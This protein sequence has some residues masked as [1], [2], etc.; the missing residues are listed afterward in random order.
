[1]SCLVIWR[2]PGNPSSIDLG[3]D[4][5]SFLSFLF[6]FLFDDSM[7]ILS[8]LFLQKLAF[9]AIKLLLTQLACIFH[10]SNV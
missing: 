10:P 1:M 6:F 9:L 3:G 7:L 8:V 4:C 2:G 5:I